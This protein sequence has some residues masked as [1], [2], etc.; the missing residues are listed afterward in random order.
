VQA[1][2]AFIFRVQS[3][4]GFGGKADQLNAYNIYR[5][6]P[7]SFADDLARYVTAT[8]ATLQG[9][10]RRWLRPELSV[11]LAVVPQGSGSGLAGAE[12]VDTGRP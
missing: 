10:A 8:S 4:G 2:S 3:L 9:A 1:E 12:P 7:D 11:A 5:Q 6:A